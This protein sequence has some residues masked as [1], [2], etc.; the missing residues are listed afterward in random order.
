MYECDLY[1]HDLRNS[2]ALAR[3]RDD[4]ILVCIEDGEK[5]SLFQH[6]L[7]DVPHASL[8]DAYADIK[9][10]YDSNGYV[11][12]VQLHSRN[13]DDFYSRIDDFQDSFP[14]EFY[15][16]VTGDARVYLTSPAQVYDNNEQ[17]GAF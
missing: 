16:R 7:A 5:A 8:A 3:L 2:I 6:T 15:A 10:S 1:T 11:G 17:F 4:L 14:A 9:R 13:A 12:S